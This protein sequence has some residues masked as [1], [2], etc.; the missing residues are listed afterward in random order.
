MQINLLST[1][2]S[3]TTT[4]QFCKICSMLDT[5][6]FHNNEKLGVKPFKTIK[7]Y[8]QRKVKNIKIVQEHTLSINLAKKEHFNSYFKIEISLYAPDITREFVP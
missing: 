6:V 2:H 7:I 3:L 5:H 8:H 4:S 1:S